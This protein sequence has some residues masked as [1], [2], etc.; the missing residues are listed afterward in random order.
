MTPITTDELNRALAAPALLIDLGK[1]I[2]E[3]GFSS[4]AIAALLGYEG[5][6]DGWIEK[7]GWFSLVWQAPVKPSMLSVLTQL[8]AL[9]RNVPTAH[10][11]TCLPADLKAALERL[12]LIAYDTPGHVACRV[13]IV[14]FDSCLCMSD[15]LFE[16]RDGKFAVITDPNTV[17]PPHISSLQLLR[18]TTVRPDFQTLLDVGCGSGCLSVPKLD[19]YAMV[20]GID[21]NPRAALFAQMNVFLNGQDA[22]RADFVC[23][24]C[25]EYTSDRKFDHILFNSPTELAYPAEGEPAGAGFTTGLGIPF[26]FDFLSNRVPLLISPRGLCQVTMLLSIPLGQTLESVVRRLV[27]QSAGKLK[28]SLRTYPESPFSLSALAIVEGRVPR[29]SMLLRNPGDGRLLI[30][31][32]RR[33]RVGQVLSVS[34]DI[35]LASSAA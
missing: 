10:Y 20:V 4:S 35:E 16:H 32:L 34:L 21:V 30:N 8:I 6:S 17:M 7:T 1:K 22:T 31:H 19:R 29:G 15:K 14:E 18:A 28:V 5:P 24:D 26:V 23:A 27:D 11:E 12:G 33:S 13:E 2:R 25:R 3:C 9:G